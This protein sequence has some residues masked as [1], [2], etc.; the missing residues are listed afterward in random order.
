MLTYAGSDAKILI[1]DVLSEYE[2]IGS[3]TGHTAPVVGLDW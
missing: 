2:W 3:C 1:Y